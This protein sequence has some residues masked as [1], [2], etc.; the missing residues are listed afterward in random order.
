MALSLD[1][2]L[3]KGAAAL[4][5]STTAK[6]DARV[7]MKHALGVDDAALIARGRDML[8]ADRLDAFDRLIARRRARE[9]VA[10]IIGEKEFWS[11]S[12]RVTPDV[13]IP[14]EDSECIIEAALERRGDSAQKAILD[15]G[16]GSGC[17][18]C[19]L[20]TEFV[21][22]E[23]LGVDRSHA[24]LKV[25][26]S[27]AERLGLTKRAKFMLGDWGGAVQGEFDIIV[28][29]PPYIRDGERAQLAPDV[30]AFE[31]DQALFAGPDGLDAYRALLK[32]IPRLLR[33]DGLLLL[34]IGENQADM[35]TKMV[36]ETLPDAVITILSDLAGRPRGVMA[37]RLIIEKK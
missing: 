7:L 26:G 34:E 22:A 24:A 31:P 11:L 36:S 18:L 13:L 3:R 14:R 27:N 5:D 6:L 21:D 35:L 28:A 10:Y 17:L 15:L 8:T 19:S 2:A 20:L 4:M 23:G 12:F 29:N 33:P 25:A 32:D 37:D 9:P 1:A 30:A 16:T